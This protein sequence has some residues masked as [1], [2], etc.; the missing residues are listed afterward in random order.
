M[1]V[2]RLLLQI[3]QPGREVR[4][5]GWSRVLRNLGSSAAQVPDFPSGPLVARW[6][7]AHK[8]LL[9]EVCTR[10]IDP[11]VLYVKQN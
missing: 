7:N 10:N 4:V 11:L 2:D 9:W 5:S 6:V 1:G 8:D 3:V